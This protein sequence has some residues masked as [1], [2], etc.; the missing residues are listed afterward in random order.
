MEDNMQDTVKVIN[1]EIGNISTGG[2]YSA[3]AD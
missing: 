2:K 3:G 1:G